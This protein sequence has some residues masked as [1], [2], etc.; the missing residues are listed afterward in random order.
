MRVLNYIIIGIVLL[1][2]IFYTG[3]LKAQVNVNVNIGTAPQWGP[4]GYTEVRYYYLPDV[5]AYYDV[6]TSMFIYYGVGGWIYRTYLPTRYR[7]YDLYSGYKVV[8]VDYHGNKPHH[9][10]KVYKNKY[11][12]GY[13]GGAQKTIGQN[14][15]NKNSN[16]NKQAKSPNKQVK[17]NNNNNN[18]NNNNSGAGNVKGGS[19]SN[20]NN[21]PS[22]QGGSGGNGGGG[23]KGGKKK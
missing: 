21:K 13:Q 4:A 7:S 1:S 10:H 9:N 11:K 20:G 23:G 8:M 2:P 6:H 17:H 12:K 3:T 14:P 19:K 5:E 16:S 22:N 18:N 15:G